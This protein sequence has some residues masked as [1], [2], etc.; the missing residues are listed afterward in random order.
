[1]LIEIYKLVPFPVKPKLP[2]EF[3]YETQYES[4]RQLQVV[5]RAIFL[6]PTLIECWERIGYKH[7]T[8]DTHEYVIQGVMLMLYPCPPP[9]SWVE[10]TLDQVV[11]T[12]TNL[13]QLGFRLSVVVFVDVII[14]IEQ[15]IIDPIGVT[16]LDAYTTFCGYAEEDVINNFLEAL[17]NPSRELKKV[18]LLDFIISRLTKPPQERIV[19]IFEN[20]KI[21][22][23]I[24]IYLDN[25]SELPMDWTFTKYTPAVYR[26]L[27]VKFGVDSIV[28]RYLMRELSTVRVAILLLFSSTEITET[29]GNANRWRDALNSFD[30]Y[31]SMGV[32]FDP[33]E[34][35]FGS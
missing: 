4:G 31:C 6:C 1:M 2:Y 16:L 23:P 9:D 3:F 20:Y 17:L 5:S 12:L 15:Y 29:L 35:L 32:A 10:P 8:E 25:P 28:T 11:Q 24:N 19:D 30:E 27:L 21:V 18:V 7:V 33:I 14:Y 22:N 26:Y 13:G 34:P